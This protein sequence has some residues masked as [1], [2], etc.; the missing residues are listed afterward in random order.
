MGLGRQL[1]RAMAARNE[2]EPATTLRDAVLHQPD[3]PEG[4]V[5]TTRSQRL[6][7]RVERLAPAV[8]VLQAR[9]VLDEYKV[10]KACLDEVREP[11]QKRDPIIFVQV[12]VRGVL[13]GEWLAGRHTRRRGRGS[14]QRRL[15]VFE[16]AR[17]P[18]ARMSASA[19]WT[20]GKFTAYVRFAAGSQSKAKTTSNPA[21]CGLEPTTGPAT[22]REEVKHLD[23]HG[24]LAASMRHP[25][26][27][28][29]VAQRAGCRL[30][31]T[32]YAFRIL[33]L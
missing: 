28:R 7:E 27:T 12:G 16:L 22:A 10:G 1:D 29:R 11:K 32:P 25:R 24:L 4:H 15:R 18:R 19:K 14:I 6:E 2:D 33:P 21:A 3:R 8:E 20:L 9:D 26:S 30:S 13:P 23:F 17:S 5:V 31:T